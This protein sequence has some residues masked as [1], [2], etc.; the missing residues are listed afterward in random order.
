MTKRQT[1]TDSRWI[2]IQLTCNNGKHGITT[3]AKKCSANLKKKTISDTLTYSNDVF[4][5]L[6]SYQK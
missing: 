4:V 2:H 1:N 5:A 3:Q 6:V